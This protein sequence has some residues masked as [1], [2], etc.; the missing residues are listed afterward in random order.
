MEEPFIHVAETSFVEG[1]FYNFRKGAPSTPLTSVAITKVIQGVLE[2]NDLPGAV[3]SLVCGSTDVGSS[4][5]ADE[6][7][8]LLSFTGSTTVRTL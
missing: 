3:S 7:I 4:M 5:V 2:K 1:F 6:K 8:N